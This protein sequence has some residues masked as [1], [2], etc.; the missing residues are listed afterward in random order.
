MSGDP[1]FVII[2]IKELSDLYDFKLDFIFC[3][4]DLFKIKDFVVVVRQFR[5]F[6]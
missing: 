2:Q 5:E 6:T 4:P 3:L 1:Y